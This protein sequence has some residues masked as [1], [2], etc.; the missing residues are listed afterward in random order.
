MDSTFHWGIDG[1]DGK[2]SCR[3]EGIMAPQ[4][5]ASD[6]EATGVEYKHLRQDL[7]NLIEHRV[8]GKLAKR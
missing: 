3:E 6:T 5:C 7:I 4:E 1:Y 2:L 8:R